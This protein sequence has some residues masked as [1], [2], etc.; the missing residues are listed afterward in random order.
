MPTPEIK[1]R[2][3]RDPPHRGRRSRVRPPGSARI[4]ASVRRN[5]PTACR[6][7]RLPRSKPRSR[8][9]RPRPRHRRYPPRGLSVAD[10]RAGTGSAARRGAGRPRLRAV[11]RHAGRRSADRRE[12]DGLL[13]RRHLFRQRPL[14]ERQGH[15]LGHVYDLGKGPARPIRKCAAMRPRNGRIST[16]TVAMSSRCYACAARSRAGCRRSSV[17]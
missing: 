16:S 14:A 15:L 6:R 13:G 17:R 4:C 5:G 10:T 2:Y 1:S 9:C 11:A 7:R 3:R 12:R 8:R